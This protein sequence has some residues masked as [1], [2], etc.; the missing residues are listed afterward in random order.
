MAG[1]TEARRP[2][3][4]L[5]AISWALLV[6]VMIG[7]YS[8]LRLLTGM[9]DGLTGH[10]EQFFRAGHGHAG[11]L[12][13]IGILY[14]GYVERAGLGYAAQVRAWL[15]YLAGVLLL[16]GGMFL[17]AFAGE[18]GDDS[19]GVWVTTVGGVTL[20]ASVLYLAWRLVRNR[21]GARRQRE[22]S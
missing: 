6:T 3:N 13:A 21:D 17:H 14:S 11:V 22:G 20:A 19:V 18:P 2:R 8:L 9:G 15:A 5:A 10:E 1:V 16:S 4:L 12:A 7:G